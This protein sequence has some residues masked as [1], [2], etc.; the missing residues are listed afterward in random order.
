MQG[1]LLVKQPKQ[2]PDGL[3]PTAAAGLATAVQKTSEQQQHRQQ[4]EQQEEQQQGQEQE[5]KGQQQEDEQQEDQ[6]GQG[7]EK[8]EKRPN[9]G[10][11][12]VACPWGE[13][14]KDRAVEGD[15]L[16]SEEVGACQPPSS[17]V[18]VC[19]ALH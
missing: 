13:A 7:E 15:Q 18:V 10:G 12:K 6:E 4:E 11:L 2:R 16:G 17:V 19:P 5:Q 1:N 3:C 14:E 8:E 9:R